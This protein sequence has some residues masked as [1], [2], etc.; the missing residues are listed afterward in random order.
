MREFLVIV[1]KAHKVVLYKVAAE[2]QVEAAENAAAEGEIIYKIEND[3]LYGIGFFVIPYSTVSVAIT[4]LK[5]FF[6]KKCAKFIQKQINV[7]QQSL[8]K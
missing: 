7:T 6:G 2:S 5:M 8:I 1:S 4:Y 3:D